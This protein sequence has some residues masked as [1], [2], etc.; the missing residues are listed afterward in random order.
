MSETS[1]S[2][3]PT[4]PTV[5]WTGLDE[6]GAAILDAFSTRG[7]GV[8]RHPLLV[9]TP[10][11]PA[12]I[13]AGVGPMDWVVV[14][15]ARA[16]DAISRIPLPASKFAAVG[17]ASAQRLHALGPAPDLVPEAKSADGLAAALIRETSPGRVLFLRGNN[18]LATLPDTLRRAGFTVAEREVYRTEPVS[19]RDA[20]AVARHIEAS[21][22]VVLFGSPAGV[23]AL[24]ETVDLKSLVARKPA[25]LLVALGKTTAAALTHAGIENPVVAASPSPAAVVRAVEASLSS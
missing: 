9:C 21:A 19:E 4:R 23:R 8:E 17:P 15:S 22:D 11:A 10:C 1:T 12:D 2:A 7:F 14:T 5:F 24:A 13:F 16:V 6:S 3:K 20:A 18:A 25:L